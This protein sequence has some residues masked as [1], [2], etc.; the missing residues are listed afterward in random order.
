MNGPVQGVAMNAASAPVR[1]AP[2]VPRAAMRLT[3]PG[4]DISNSPA[5]LSAMPVTSS[6]RI[7]MTRGS[8]S[9]NAQPTLDPAARSPSNIPPSSRQTRITP[10]A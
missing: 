2:P 6:N 1:N 10:A 9:W 4:A 3:T 5:K 8:W 7:R